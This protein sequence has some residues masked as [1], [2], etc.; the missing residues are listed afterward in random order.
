MTYYRRPLTYE[1]MAIGEANGISKRTM[2]KRYN[3]YF[4]SAERTI[5][6]PINPPGR[7][8][9]YPKEW[10]EIAAENGIIA[11]TFRKRCKRGMPPEIAAT[12][13]LR[14]GGFRKGRVS[15]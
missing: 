10:E 5:T 12:K 2:H 14:N 7:E 15:V 13:P 4:W 6:E 3:D 9:K 1:E 8:R 11:D